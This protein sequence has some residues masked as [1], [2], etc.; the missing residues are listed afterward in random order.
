MTR[1]FPGPSADSYVSVGMKLILESFRETLSQVEGDE[2]MPCTIAGRLS[3]HG[4]KDFLLSLRET[5][6]F[7][8]ISLSTGRALPINFMYR[9]VGNAYLS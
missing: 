3:V 7:E 6:F 4:I 2:Q 9:Q 8:A 1:Q 5:F